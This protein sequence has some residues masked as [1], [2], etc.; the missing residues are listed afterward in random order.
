MVRRLL[1][2]D[3]LKEA[4]KQRLMI[5]TLAKKY[6]LPIEKELNSAMLD[7]IAHWEMTGA[8]VYPRGF[9]DQMR[10]HYETMTH[11]A[12]MMF[13]MRI[14]EHGKGYKPE[15][16]TKGFFETMTRLAS[17]YIS[18][19]AIRRRITEVT[20]TTRNQIVRAVSKGYSGGLGQIQ[21]AK[22]IREAVPIISSARAGMI[23]RTEVH[24]AANYGANE[25]A[26]ETGLPLKREWLAAHDDRTRTI[27]PLIGDPD[28]YGHLQADGQI[29]TKDTPFMIP[30]FGGKPEP[31]MYPGDPN[32]RA[33]NVINCRC[34]TAFVVDEEAFDEMLFSDD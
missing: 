7:M 5:E 24:A 19:E 18:L 30:R 31:L 27:E 17:K 16:E 11:A 26:K 20:E 25:A 9:Q 29:V 13:G 23:A 32:G 22:V 33:G 28:Q 6:A 10:G 1:E 2:Q 3:R 21:T 34:T 12:I 14:L 8:I 15:L 4:E